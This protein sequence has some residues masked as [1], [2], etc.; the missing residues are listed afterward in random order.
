MNEPWKCT[1]CGKEMEGWRTRSYAD[2][3]GPRCSLCVSGEHAALA[4]E[5]RVLLGF[6]EARIASPLGKTLFLVGGNRR[7]TV[8]D[9]IQTICNGKIVPDFEYIETKYAG[10]GA[11][12]DE[13]RA[14][15]QE[16]IRLSGM[17]WEAV[18]SEYLARTGMKEEEH[19][20]AIEMYKNTRE[21]MLTH[22]VDERPFEEQ[23]EDL[24]RSM[25]IG[26]I[27]PE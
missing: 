19:L 5:L 9:G 6:D 24:A 10:S 11:T 27:D 17:T 22:P 13:L 20:V 1:E 25:R 4:E 16:Y 7:N 15:V 8:S 21:Y 18:F 23:A 2:G 26:G 14:S 12:P 3:K